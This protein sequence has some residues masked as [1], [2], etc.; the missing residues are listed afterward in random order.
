MMLHIDM[1]RSAIKDWKHA[2]FC[3]LKLSILSLNDDK[4]DCPSSFRNRLRYSASLSASL[5][6]MYSVSV[7]DSAKVRFFLESHRITPPLIVKSNLVNDRLSLMDPAQ[8]AST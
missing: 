6:A 5:K 7:V 1:L 8:S 3:A 2:T 4:S